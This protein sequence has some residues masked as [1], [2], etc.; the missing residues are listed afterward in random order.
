MGNVVLGWNVLFLMPRAPDV[1][2]SDVDWVSDASCYGKANVADWRGLPME[3]WLII[4]RLS[5]A[6]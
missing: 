3:M 1:Y 4:A 2:I 6:P 5:S